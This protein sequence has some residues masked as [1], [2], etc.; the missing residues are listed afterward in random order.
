MRYMV[1]FAHKTVVCALKS[2]SNSIKIAYF[3]LQNRKIINY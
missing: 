2:F 1:E 3:A